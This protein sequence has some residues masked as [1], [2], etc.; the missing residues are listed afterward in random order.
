M[1]ASWHFDRRRA[2]AMILAEAGEIMVGGAYTAERVAKENA[3]VDTGR[4]RAGTHTEIV[5]QSEAWVYND[6]EYSPE[7]EF[8]HDSD[9]G[10]P[11]MR[12][13]M[14]A[15]GAYIDAEIARRFG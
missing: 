8:G 12:P 14:R 3:R 7:N 6:V 1:S 2:E 11:F 13:G 5:S 4:M 15:G 9:P 10:K